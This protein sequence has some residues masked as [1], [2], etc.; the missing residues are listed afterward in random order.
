M[1]KREVAGTPRLIQLNLDAAFGSASLFRLDPEFLN[2]RPPF[3]GIGLDKRPERLRCLSLT[4][5]I[6]NPRSMSR[7]RTAGSANASTAAALSLPM[8][9]FGV[10]LGAKSP[11]QAE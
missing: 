9:S 8:M 1:S 4:R 3:L 6:S 10:P 11:T 2:D 7:D 5:K